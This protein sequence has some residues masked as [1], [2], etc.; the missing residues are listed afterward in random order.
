[1]TWTGLDDLTEAEYSVAEGSDS[2]GE[3]TITLTFATPNKIAYAGIYTC[4]FLYEGLPTLSDE[5][6]LVVRCEL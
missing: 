5:V 3:R 6:E 4:N 1:M 2:G